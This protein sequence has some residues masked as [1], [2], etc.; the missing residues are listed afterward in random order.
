ML[1]LLAKTPHPAHHFNDIH[2]PQAAPLQVSHLS[3]Q[4]QQ[5]TLVDDISFALKHGELCVVLGPNGAG[6]SSLLKLISGEIGLAGHNIR[7][8][9]QPRD[10][11][12]DGLLAQHLAI[13]PQHSQLSFA[14]SALEVAQLGGL[15]LPVS[16][17][18]I[19]RIAEQNM[20]A[21]DVLHLAQRAY[22]SL[23]G[24]EKQR[25]HLAR[26]L[27]QLS[28][29][30]NHGLL[31]LD[32]PTSALDLAQQHKVL[33]LCQRLCQQGIT[34]LMVLHDLNLAAQYADRI[35]LLKSGQLRVDSAPT[36]ALTTENIEQIYQYSAKV[37]A[38]PELG[39]PI[40]MSESNH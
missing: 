13:L 37:M 22:P 14:F 15:S 33:Q 28:R 6:K 5:Q 40:V 2:I 21:T 10:I 9:G 27:T 34:V 24:G 4:V 35:L 32:E 18:K 26:V 38:H 3:Y 29:A 7:L 1:R 11:W 8:F 30:N 19:R 25:V 12:P 16:Q 31:I 23:S 17:D 36:E 39:Y 20:Q